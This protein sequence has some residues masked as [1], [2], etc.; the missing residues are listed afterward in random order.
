MIG[1][2]IRVSASGSISN[3]RP[4][5][6]PDGHIK[7]RPGVSLSLTALCLAAVTA[8]S[9]SSGGSSQRST[10]TD[11]GGP[12]S[13]SASSNTLA[14]SA[15]AAAKAAVAKFENPST[16]WRGPTTGPALLP[17]KTVAFVAASLD[18]AN[19][20]SW[21]ND[22]KAAATAAGWKFVLINGHGNV[23]G[24]AQ[25]FNQAIALHVDG[26]ISDTSADSVQPELASAAAKGIP[27]IGFNFVADPGPSAKSKV[28][29][30]LSSGP[31]V[32]G[33][34]MADD[35][36]AS[37]D[38]KGQS[39]ILYDP[40]YAVAVAKANGM[41]SALAKCTGCKLLEFKASPLANVNTDLGPLMTH[42]YQQYGA[43]FYAMAITDVYFDYAIPALRSSGVAPSAVHLIGSGGAP[44]A[45]QRIASDE[46]QD[47]TVADPAPEWGYQAIDEINRVLHH[48]AVVRFVEPPLLITKDN[49]TKFGGDASPPQYS[50]PDGF[51]CAYL[52]IW[53][54][55]ASG[56]S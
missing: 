27:V 30:N 43:G 36:I 15:V 54:V 19:S 1:G 21:A 25:A 6:S 3:T 37:S 53:Q 45:Y 39:T 17:R 28:T 49:V 40:A 14:G 46:Y 16:T 47:A 10:T 12:A 8:C 41:K 24:W 20:D 22:A 50:P 31:E 2:G 26:I 42:W 56:C 34:A 9:S 35:V 7:R 13:T 55:Q 52:K 33:Q 4:R 44:T 5:T 23:Q 51:R 18:A 11:A 38:G 29:Y 32:E 48:Q